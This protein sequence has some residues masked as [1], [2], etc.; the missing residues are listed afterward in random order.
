[1]QHVISTGRLQVQNI[2]K[3]I[4]GFAFKICRWGFKVVD[5]ILQRIFGTMERLID[6]SRAMVE[7][8]EI[9]GERIN[10]QRLRRSA[11]KAKERRMSIAAGNA[12]SVHPSVPA[13][14]KEA[15]MD[16]RRLICRCL[17]G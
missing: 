12:W 2:N 14:I 5:I 11:A 9:A 13:H 8:T 15:V 1:M 6:T 16:S 3:H 10:R 4:S 7:D 17:T